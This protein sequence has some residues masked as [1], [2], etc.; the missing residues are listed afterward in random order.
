MFF[1]SLYFSFSSFFSPLDHWLFTL[2][3]FPP[4]V[5]SPHRSGSISLVELQEYV[6][7]V[8]THAIL[9][10]ENTHSNCSLLSQIESSYHVSFYILLNTYFSILL[11]TFE[12]SS[13][14]YVS[15]CVLQVSTE[16]AHAATRVL[17]SYQ[18]DASTQINY[19]DFLAAAMC[20]Y[21]IKSHP[22]L[23]CPILCSAVLCY[24]TLS[25]LSLWCC[26][27]FCDALL[28]P[29]PKTI[30]LLLRVHN[31]SFQSPTKLSFIL[32]TSFS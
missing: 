15:V 18:S 8:R 32:T 26:A 30:K 31:H 28:H 5:F 7:K 29:S 9:K 22:V 6:A 2:S 19:I 1:L 11:N 16:N 10:H 14:S 25:C 27:M 21:V 17:E 20:K 24:D 23:Y 4:L 12:I 3:H 13:E